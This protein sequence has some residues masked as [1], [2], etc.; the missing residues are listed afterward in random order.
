METTLGRPSASAI[1][2]FLVFVLLTLAITWWAAKRTRSTR[3]FYAAGRRVSGCV[4]WPIFVAMSS[5]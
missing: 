3:E 1:G 5:A 2:F 4:G